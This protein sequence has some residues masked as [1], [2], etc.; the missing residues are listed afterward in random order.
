MGCIHLYTGDGK[1]KTTAAMG[2][3]LR[4]FGSGK[5]VL[6]TQFL[7]G[8]PSGELASFFRL[9]VEVWRNSREYNFFPFLTQEEK[10]ALIAEQNEQLHRIQSALAMDEYDMIILDELITAVEIGAVDMELVKNLFA[11]APY[12]AELV[13]TGHNAPQWMVQKADYVTEMK[14]VKHPYQSG[15]PAR[16]GIEY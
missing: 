3:A 12:D 14:C 2:L 7:K 16:E 4:G 13:F 9:D 1:G 15:L 8:G 5:R 10:D 11:N 6:I